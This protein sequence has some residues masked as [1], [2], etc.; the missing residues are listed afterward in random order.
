MNAVDALSRRF[1]ACEH[2]RFTAVAEG[3]VVAEVSNAASTATIS[4][5]GGQVLAWHPGHQ[6]LPVLWL[7]KRVKYMPGKAIRG[8]VPLCWPWFGAHPTDAGAP[9]H[10]YARRC[11]W[12][13]SSVRALP[14]GETELLL[15]LPADAGGSRSYPGL[16]LAVRIIVGSTLTVEATATNRG[17]KPVTYTE[18]MHTYL[19]IGDIAR[20]RVLGLEG[21]EYADLLDANAR[22]RQQGRIEFDGEFGRVYVDTEATCTIEDDLLERRIVVRKQGSL[23]TAVWNPWLRTAGM[24]D[25]LGPDGW[26]DMVCVETANALANA[27]TLDAGASHTM[28]ATYSAEDRG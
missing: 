28:S 24:M 13:M 8:G 21:A 23:S 27:V 16:H 22:K 12:E 3:I 25:D 26:R 18:G 20:I 5:Y 15:E 14:G 10:G 9:A 4:L 17:S 2:V 19:R 6:A 7:S 1:S 11:P